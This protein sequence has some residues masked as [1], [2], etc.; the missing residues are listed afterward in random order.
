MMRGETR[1]C[2][3]VSSFLYFLLSLNIVSLSLL[4][5]LGCLAGLGCSSTAD[6]AGDADTPA[7][8]QGDEDLGH[9]AAQ[10]TSC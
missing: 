8:H 4:A 7:T 2:W 10:V 1:R 9:E 3:Q 5:L 6:A